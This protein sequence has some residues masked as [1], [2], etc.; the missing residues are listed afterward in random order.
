MTLFP[1]A[2]FH[3]SVSSVL[4]SWV[5]TWVENIDTMISILFNDWIKLPFEI[6]SQI[7]I[8]YWKWEGDDELCFLPFF[9]S[10]CC[11]L[12]LHFE[13]SMYESEVGCPFSRLPIKA[14]GHHL[15]SP[16]YRTSLC[17]F[18]PSLYLLP[19]HDFKAKSWSCDRR[20]WLIW[21]QATLNS[22][23]LRAAHWPVS[24][25]VS[26]RLAKFNGCY[27]RAHACSPWVS[28]CFIC[29]ISL[30]SNFCNSTPL[31]KWNSFF[32]MSL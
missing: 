12:L 19:F 9:V 24:L 23:T 2:S 13:G 27:Y 1:L 18:C 17:Q 26:K 16:V 5:T 21:A 32:E 4:C 11:W 31:P 20:L 8:F 7:K 28:C 3:F 22:I 25:W 10:L 15:N 6:L 14:N 29:H 30:R